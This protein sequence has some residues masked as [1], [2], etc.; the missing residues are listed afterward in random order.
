M[1]GRREG[2]GLLEHPQFWVVPPALC[3]LAGAFLNRDRLRPSQ[4]AA[5]RHAAASAVYLSS[6]ADLVVNGVAEDPW[7]PLVLGGLS[8]LGIF[9]GIALRVRGFLLLGSAFLGLSVFSIV[10]YAAVD[11][12]QTWL[13]A[14]SGIVAG[15]L[16]LAAFAVFEKRHREVMEVVERIRHWEA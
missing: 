15:V 12:R 5:L 9:A 1:L 6:T 11:L 7:L 2:L 8:L 13:W 3:V 10:W 16:I 4:S 14:A